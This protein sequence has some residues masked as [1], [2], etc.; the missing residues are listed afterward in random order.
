MQ[1]Y[2][3]NIVN[4]E[5]FFPNFGKMSYLCAIIPNEP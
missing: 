2:S 4:Y 3:Q 5:Y 1:M